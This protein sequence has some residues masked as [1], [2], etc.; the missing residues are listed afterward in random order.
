MVVGGATVHGFTVSA[1]TPGD[2]PTPWVHP[3]HKAKSLDE[4]DVPT[5]RCAI[6]LASLQNTARTSAR[7]VLIRV[8]VVLIALGWQTSA[9]GPP[10]H[11]AGI[12]LTK[13]VPGWVDICPAATT[14]VDQQSGVSC[15]APYPLSV[16]RQHITSSR[17]HVI[18]HVYV[19][20]YMVAACTHGSGERAKGAVP[21]S[22]GGC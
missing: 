6:P 17:D 10:C 1:Q 9:T 22:Q 12:L 11:C 5:H 16:K 21:E 7:W 2:E 14:V 8:K 13:R 15:V 4:V 20:W 3:S 19:H 18:T